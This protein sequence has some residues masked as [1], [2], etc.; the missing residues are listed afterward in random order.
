MAGLDLVKPGHDEE[1]CLLLAN[2]L[3]Q[4]EPHTGV[5]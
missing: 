4:R 3:C 5:V 2:R 1:W